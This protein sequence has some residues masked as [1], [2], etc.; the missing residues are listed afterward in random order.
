MGCVSPQDNQCRAERSDVGGRR[1]SKLRHASVL[2]HAPQIACPR[3][4][5]TLL[6][7]SPPALLDYTPTPFASGFRFKDLLERVLSDPSASFSLSPAPGRSL[8]DRPFSRS[9]P[10]RPAPTP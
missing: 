5:R 2:D 1:R 8:P 4:F 9:S 6:R 10:T 7:W 3:R